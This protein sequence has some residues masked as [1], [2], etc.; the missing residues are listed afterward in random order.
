MVEIERGVYLAHDAVLTAVLHARRLV[1]IVTAAADDVAEELGEMVW[2]Y[3]H[4]A[5]S[6]PRS[7]DVE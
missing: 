3:R 7:P 4:M 5:G 6:E 2:D 1:A